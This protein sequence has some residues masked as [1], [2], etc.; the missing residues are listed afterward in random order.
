MGHF[1]TGKVAALLGAPTWKI[2][3]ILDGLDPHLPRAG[4]YRLVPESLLGKVSEE[5]QKRGRLQQE[6]SPSC[7]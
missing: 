6:E 5:L 3:R 7:R 4:L 2:R 1:T